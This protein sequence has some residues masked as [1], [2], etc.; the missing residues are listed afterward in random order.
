M[1]LFTAWMCVSQKTG[2]TCQVRP[3]RKRTSEKDETP[4]VQMPV[5][6]FRPYVMNCFHIFAYC[7]ASCLSV[8]WSTFWKRW[9]SWYPYGGSAT[10]WRRWKKLGQ[11]LARRRKVEGVMD[12][13]EGGKQHFLNG[14]CIQYI[15]IYLLRIHE[16]YTLILLI[17]HM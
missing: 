11:M 10:V 1:R 5:L 17:H 16:I 6:L 3:M 4:E 7:F 2:G 14:T 13:R 12:L 15:C 9:G 8:F